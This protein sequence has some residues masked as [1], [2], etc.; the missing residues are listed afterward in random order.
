MNVN[1]NQNA[2]IYSGDVKLKIFKDGWFYKSL[3][4]HNAGTI[5]FLKFIRDCVAG[6]AGIYQRIPFYIKPATSSGDLAANSFSATQDIDNT[7]D[8]EIS[9]IYTFLLSGVNYSG[10][11]ITKLKLYNSNMEL[12]A[13][14]ELLDEAGNSSPITITKNTNIYV[15]WKLT[16]KNSSTVVEDQEDNQ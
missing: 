4:G 8:E 15:E 7:S 6:K 13:E 1:I 3:G 9:I 5:E 10:Y 11:T 16:F 2:I 14:Y 12:Y